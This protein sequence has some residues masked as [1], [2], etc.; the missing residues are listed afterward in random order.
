MLPNEPTASPSPGEATSPVADA[1][2]AP[3]SRRFYTGEKLTISEA[4]QL[5]RERPACVVLC[6]GAQFSGKTTFLA[7]V[8]EMFRDG[9]FAPYR[10]GGSLTLCAFERATWRATITSGAEHPDTERTHRRENDTFLHL[11][12]Y[13]AGDSDGRLELLI[14]DLAGETFPTAVASGEF[15]ADLR[16]LARADHLVIFLDCA[17]LADQVKRHPERDN[18]RGFLQQVRKVKHQPTALQVHVVFSRW[19]YVTRHTDRAALEK[20][21]EATEADFTERFSNS[22]ASIQ[23]RRI[24][25]RP[26]G[27]IQP[28][29]EEIQSLFAH[30]LEPPIHAPAPSATRNRQPVRDFCAFGL[31]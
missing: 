20:F 25:A 24:A 18:A 27:G 10:F 21:C 6:A 4:S 5:L 19:D 26:D 7:R 12:V 8:G 15:C 23:F 11:R 17:N 9:S 29:N 30:W 2:S 14:S 31:T 16:S 13:P 1:P 22:F 28:T 3:E